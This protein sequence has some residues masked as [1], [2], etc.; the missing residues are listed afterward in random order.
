MNLRHFAAAWLLIGTGVA[1]GHTQRIAINN[2][3]D[4]LDQARMVTDMAARGALY[5]RVWQQQAMDLP[6]IY[7]YTPRYIMGARKQVQGYRVP[8]DGLIRLQGVSLAAP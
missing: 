5:G 6:I 3:P 2:D 7:L 4:I 8:P 1:T